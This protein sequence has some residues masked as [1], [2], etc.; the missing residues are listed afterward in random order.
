MQ[1]VASSSLTATAI[2]TRPQGRN[3]TLAK[4]LK[5]Q[6]VVSLILPALQIEAMSFF[7]V[8]K[9][10]PS[11]YDIVVF[12]SSK[13]VECYLAALRAHNITWPA[14]VYAASVGAASARPLHNYPGLSPNWTI[15]PNEA[16]PNQ[17]SEALWALLT[18]R[19]LQAKRVLILR[20]QQGREWLGS[21]FESTNAVVERVTVYR[22]VPAIW[23]AQQHLALKQAL[24]RGPCVCL[25]TSSESVCAMI[26]NVVR[27]G[28]EKAWVKQRFVAIHDRIAE[29][30]QLEHQALGL[31]QA[32]MLF[33]SSPSVESMCDAIVDA[34]SVN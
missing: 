34:A 13:A 26:Q 3:A 27:L 6:G 24:L 10:H 7:D 23:T 5:E 25:L 12:V 9:H 18:Q 1:R 17:D 20:G 22:R 29:R 33:R 11:L 14:H 28:L 2:L 19:Q 4:A 15:H 8:S 16:D 31:P 21:R 32:T 30:L